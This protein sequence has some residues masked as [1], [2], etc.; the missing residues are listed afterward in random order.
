MCR[1]ATKGWPPVTHTIH[2][3]VTALC[4]AV[5]ALIRANRAHVL[6]SSPAPQFA[7]CS[8]L[9]KNSNNLLIVF[10][11]YETQHSSCLILSKTV[12]NYIKS[13]FREPGVCAALVQ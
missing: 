3:T 13:Q 6:H 2:E 9:T 11:S 12:I 8:L 4:V 1:G 7:G 5:V 10:F